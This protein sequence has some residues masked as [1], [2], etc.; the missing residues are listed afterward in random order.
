VHT[1]IQAS[2][3]PSAATDT[4]PCIRRKLLFTINYYLHRWT[5]EFGHR[6]VSVHT[7]I[8]T[9]TDRHRQTQAGTDRHRA[10][11]KHSE[12]TWRGR[13]AP[14]PCHMRM[15]VM[16]GG[17]YTC[18]TRGRDVGDRPHPRPHYPHTGTLAVHQPL[19]PKTL[20]PNPKHLTRH[21]PLLLM[22]C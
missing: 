18:H 11:Q 1:S 17:G 12:G 21:P 4:C 15:H 22:Y 2:C 9:D 16:W 6:H 20:T 14:S 7:H 8:Q 5:S 13:Q 10:R 3:L 19:L